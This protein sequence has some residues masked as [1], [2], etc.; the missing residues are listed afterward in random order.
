MHNKINSKKRPLFAAALAAAVAAGWLVFRPGASR[1]AVAGGPAAAAVPVSTAAVKLGSLDIYIDGIG[2]VTPISTIT[3][4]SR[5]VGELTEVAYQ[6]GQIVKKGDLLAV[7]DPRPYQAALNQAQGQLARDQAMLRNARLDLARYQDAYRQHA[8]P[9]QQLATQQAVVDGDAGVVQLDQGNLESAQVNVDYTRIVSPIDGRV[10]LR[11]VDSG[12]IV[13]ANGTV[14]LATITQLQPITVIFTIAEDSLSEV[15]PA[16]NG[17][18]PLKVLALDRTQQKQLATGTLLTLDNQVDPATGTVKARAVFPNEAN[19]LYPNQFV[20][21]RL[22]LKTLTQVDL[23]PSAAIQLNDAQ[24]FVYVVQPDGT[25]QS[26]NV[27]VTAIDG[28]TAAVTGVQMGESVVID[29]FDRLQ[30]GMKVSI[31][32]Q[33]AASAQPAVAPPKAAGAP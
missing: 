22:V 8:I 10:G 24:R 16:V 28:E 20:N 15:L 25:V 7:I 32:R 23:I 9:E 11:Q 31:R 14:P 29:G 18:Q 2:T 33:P 26:R 17:S 12:N 19:E 30:A 4:T 21:A 3:V 6:E 13:Q 5:V 1:A 27:N